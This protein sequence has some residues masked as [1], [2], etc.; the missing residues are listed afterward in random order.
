MANHL[1]KPVDANLHSGMGAEA[2]CASDSPHEPCTNEGS[3]GSAARITLINQSY[4]VS[5]DADPANS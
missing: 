5:E 3:A 4:R 1:H 2:S